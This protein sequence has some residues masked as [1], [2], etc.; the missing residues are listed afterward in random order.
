MKANARLAILACAVL[1]LTGTAAF[2]LDSTPV[3]VDAAYRNKH[4]ST[5]YTNAVPLTWD[6]NTNAANATLA[7]SGMNS[8]FATNFTAV[9]SNYLW[10]VSGT[11][12]PA[13][14]DVYDLTLT[15]YATGGA[16]VGALTSRLAVVTGAFGQTPVNPVANSRSWSQV[17]NNVVIPYDA[18]WPEAD[19]NATSA[20]LVIAKNG[21]ATETN[22]FDNVAGY[23]G[24]KLVRSNWGYGTFDLT[25][26]FPG[27][28]NIWTAELT[29]P[30]DG[31]IIKM[32]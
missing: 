16:T 10:Q 17:K 19:T 8:A 11:S 14:E 26:S 6:W 20:Q 18:S 2:A 23:T 27:A 1:T 9:T 4:W 7:V 29:R 3:L 24:W 32:K 22:A 30:M 5:V 13:L 28:T 31:T 25:L 21:G 15:F 12:V